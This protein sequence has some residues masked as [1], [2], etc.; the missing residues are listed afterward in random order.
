[1][2]DFQKKD[3]VKIHDRH[4]ELGNKVVFIYV[5][6]S[7]DRYLITYREK[8][9][10]IYKPVDAYYLTKACEQDYPEIFI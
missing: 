8:G 5:N 3:L 9:A 4:P 6:L 2:A 7:Y 10:T 1:M